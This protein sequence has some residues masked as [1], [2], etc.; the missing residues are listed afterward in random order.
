VDP[1]LFV[2]ITLRK[3]LHQPTA[4]QAKRCERAC[5]ERHR[6]WIPAIWSDGRMQQSNDRKA[7]KHDQ[8][9]RIAP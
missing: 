1:R 6:D 5:A 7:G 9:D 2:P 3:R 4:A 8:Q